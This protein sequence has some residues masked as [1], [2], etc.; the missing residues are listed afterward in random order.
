ML[1][2]QRIDQ[3]FTSSETTFDP[4][5]EATAIEFPAKD[6]SAGQLAGKVHRLDARLDGTAAAAGRAQ[7]IGGAGVLAAVV[8][9]VIGL[10]AG[11]RRTGA[12]GGS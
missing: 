3:S 7:T 5:R 1:K 2:Q 11:R 4:V 9:I 12:S 6:P 10:A 8:G